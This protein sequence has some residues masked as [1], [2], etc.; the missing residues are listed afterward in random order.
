MVDL[1]FG[2]ILLFLTLFLL[3]ALSTLFGVFHYYH[4]VYT[5]ECESYVCENVHANLRACARACV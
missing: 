3:Y 2:F 4:L 1:V 5:Y